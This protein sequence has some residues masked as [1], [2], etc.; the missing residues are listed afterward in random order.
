MGQCSGRDIETLKLKYEQLAK[1]ISVINQFT[2]IDTRPIVGTISAIEY[3]DKSI[4]L[5]IEIGTDS[6]NLYYPL[7]DNI[8]LPHLFEKLIF[9]K[10]L[11]KTNKPTL[12]SEVFVINYSTTLDRY[13]GD[14]S[15]NKVRVLDVNL[16][17]DIGDS[18]TLF[19]DS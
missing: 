8:T 11:C 16:T 18:G 6:H 5:T 17:L 4:Q 19:K 9:T 7:E 12:A 13:L 1:Q 14:M 2:S 10:V 3:A 15:W